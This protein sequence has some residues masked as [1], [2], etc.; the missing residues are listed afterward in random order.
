MTTRD[1]QDLVMEALD[2]LNAEPDDDDAMS[3][4][5]FADVGMLTQNAG[6][7]LRIGDQEF[8][9]SLVRSR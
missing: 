3:I 6:V 5:T 7:V 4:L 9:I 1:V 2:L 8:Q